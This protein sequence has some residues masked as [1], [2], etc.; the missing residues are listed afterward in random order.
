MQNFGLQIAEGSEITNLTVPSGTS[1]PAND[2]VGEMF[3]RT[4]LDTM[5][6]RNNTE[7]AVSGSSSK[8]K[9]VI[10]NGDFDIWQRGTTQTS[11]G[12]GSEDRWYNGNVGSTKVHSRQEFTVGQTDVPNNPQ[13]YSRTVVASVAGAGNYAIK[14]QNIENVS[15][16]AGETVTVSFWAKADANKNIV[17]SFYQYFGSGGS[18]ASAAITPTTHSL[19]TSWQKFTVTAAI[20]SISGKTVGVNNFLQPVFWLEAGSNLDADT[21][22]LGQQSGTFDIAQVQ[23]EKG[24]TATDFE[25]RSVGEE[26]ALCQR[27]YQHLVLGEDYINTINA[28]IFYRYYTFNTT[29]RIPPSASVFTQLRYYSTGGAGADFTPSSFGP[30][31]YGLSIHS[32]GMVNCKG[33]VSGIVALDADL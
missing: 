33:F 9:N 27:Y 20:P 7:W 5:Y 11:S 14:Y 17:S 19:T 21:N 2:N 26:L 1:F 31:V 18:A 8:N 22:S 4:D 23:L 28:T 6:V 3:Y 16:F 32:G 30:K 24:S 29:M 13:Y 25:H 10:I 15:T 12:Y